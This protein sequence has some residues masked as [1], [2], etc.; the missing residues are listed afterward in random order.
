MVEILSDTQRKAEQICHQGIELC[1]EK[2]LPGAHGLFTQAYQLD[3]TSP[4][5][6][7]WL[8]YTTAVVERKV[9]KGVELC[10]KAVEGEV[11]DALFYRNLGK[12]FLLMNNKRAAIGAFA[13]GLQI[14]KGN[15][16]ILNE[17]KMLGFRRRVLFSFLDRDHPLNKWIGKL[18]WYL[19]HRNKS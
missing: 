17:W 2:D 15:R 1:D 11:P 19:T 6:I 8:G 3:P 13:K 10:R 7:S 18:T 16:H 9:Q 5:I 4:K 12:A 14:D